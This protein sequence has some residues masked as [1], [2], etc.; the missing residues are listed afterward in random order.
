[1][2]IQPVPSFSNSRLVNSTNALIDMSYVASYVQAASLM[3]LD[4]HNFKME[5]VFGYVFRVVMIL[6]RSRTIDYLEEFKL[7]IL[8]DIDHLLESDLAER[9]RARV[10]ALGKT[11]ILLNDFINLVMDTIY[12]VYKVYNHLLCNI[13]AE[14]STT[15]SALGHDSVEYKIHDIR[16]LSG[17]EIMVSIGCYA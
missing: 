1:M 4:A 9:H 3:Q 15:C 10:V 16:N 17:Q 11:T 12:K 2:I 7:F 5:Q 6:K 14:L 8:N 13:F